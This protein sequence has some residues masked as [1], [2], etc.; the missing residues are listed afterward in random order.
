MEINLPAF[1]VN[2]VEIYLGKD[3]SEYFDRIAKIIDLS[4]K[5]EMLRTSLEQ[6]FSTKIVLEDQTDQM[7]LLTYFLLS[8]WSKE[9]DSVNDYFTKFNDTID[10]RNLSFLVVHI[11]SL[12][13][14]FSFSEFKKFHIEAE[15]VVDELEDSREKEFLRLSLKEFSAETEKRPEFGYKALNEI[16]RY[17]LNMDDLSVQFPF[18]LDALLSDLV[19]FAYVIVDDTLKDL[20]IESAVK[21]AEN[22]NNDGML[23]SLYDLLANISMKEYDMKKA[24]E[25]IDKGVSIA[26]KLKSDRLLVTMQLNIATKE[27]MNGKL[28]GA[29]VIYKN[30]LKI[31]SLLNL[32]D[33][34]T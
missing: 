5:E 33:P 1:I 19:N 12:R 4:K 34:L 6:Y 9:Y 21:R 20:W 32:L 14:M 13:N 15:K 8:Y 26:K 25:Y 29:L 16:L 28:N 7:I 11:L 30:M 10:K 22:F 17:L 24:E 18:I 3:K 31:E 27:K 23:C 2:E